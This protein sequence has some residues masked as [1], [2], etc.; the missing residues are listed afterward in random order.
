MEFLID[1]G[2]DPTLLSP[3]DAQ[4]LGLNLEG[5]PAGPASTGVGGRTRTVVV[6]GVLVLH[7]RPFPL[8]VRV[9]DPPQEQSELFARVPSLLGR[10]ILSQFALFFEQRTGRVL[11]LTQEEAQA[12]P[13][14]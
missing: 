9:L 5:L 8:A 7:G 11:L 12:L 1:T 13:L 4:R 3:R 6:D 2:A 14:P 10:D